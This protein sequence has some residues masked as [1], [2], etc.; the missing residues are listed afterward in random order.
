MF[1]YLLV[2]L[3]IF[4]HISASSVSL[5]YIISNVAFHIIVYRFQSAK[6]NKFLNL[7]G[8]AIISVANSILII[9]II[10]SIVFLSTKINDK[11]IIKLQ[12]STMFYHIYDIKI[13]F[14]D[15]E[16]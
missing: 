5:I 4:P 7:Y 15:Y 11:T 2:M 9:S 13:N 16:K 10:M 12:K 3:F 6:E 1:N 8:G 14:I